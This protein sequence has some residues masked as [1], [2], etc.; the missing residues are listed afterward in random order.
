MCT[1]LNID[2]RNMIFVVKMKIQIIFDKIIFLI[3]LGIK[4]SHQTTRIY[5]G[6]EAIERKMIQ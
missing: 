3:L 6:T 1:L 5:G 4:M 2:R